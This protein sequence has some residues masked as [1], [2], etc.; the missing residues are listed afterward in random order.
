MAKPSILFIG[1]KENVFCEIAQDTIRRSFPCSS[2]AIGKRGDPFPDDLRNWRGDYVLSYLSPW[3]V[4]ECVLKN[5][6]T[7]A[8]N[9]HTGPPEYPG[10]GCTNFAIYNGESRVGVTCH[11]MAPR[12]DTGPII[13][14][15]RFPLYEHDSGWSLTQRCYVAIQSLF[16]EIIDMILDGRELPT[17]EEMWT[18]TPYKRSELNAL[19]EITLDMSES[20][21]ARRVRAVTFPGAPGAFIVINGMRFDCV[22]H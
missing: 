17:S 15:R 8:V 18:R 20:E 10:I 14:V 12:V 5:A 13:A 7:A 1:K 22:D 4:P 11:H 21:I 19:C 9:F 2:L 3:I 6:A 16:Y